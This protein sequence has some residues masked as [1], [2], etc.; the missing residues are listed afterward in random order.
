M[1]HVS[2]KLDLFESASENLK[3]L[4]N[5]PG[6][7]VKL[8]LYAFFK[9]ATIGKC[10]IKKPFITDLVGR[11]KWD[12]WNELKNMEKIE[13][14]EKYI[15]LVN[16]LLKAENIHLNE[17]EQTE[18]EPMQEIFTK[19]NNK[20]KEIITSIEFGNVFKIT[21]NRPNKFNAFSKE[22]YL[23]V[24]AAIKEANENENILMLC[25]T[26][27]GEYFSSGNDL[28]NF[29]QITG[30]DSYEKLLRSGCQLVE[31]LCDTLI[32]FSKPLI[33][34]VNGPA[35]GI[36]F[37]ILGL[38]DYVIASEKA[39]FH[40]PFT[41]L[42]LSPEGCSSY[43]FPKIMGNLK[44]AEVLLFNKKL[45]AQEA[46]ECGFVSEIIPKENFEIRAS[47]KLKILSKIPK[48]S[49]L[50]STKLFRDFNRDKDKL[51]EVNKTEMETLYQRF[52]SGD[53]LQSVMAFMNK[54]SKL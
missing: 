29:T 14:K 27:N 35:V 3:L 21:L 6:N 11:A 26:G 41:Q 38:F 52:L 44:A 42:A 7:D 48:D 25:L 28:T 23:E 49:L 13:A 43:T 40:C 9:Q 47:E 45:S 54:K 19:E 32:D 5:E 46:Y 33:A 15:D 1:S 36:S 20:Y 12:S 10:N 51:K 22:M 17:K 8:K 37:T 18:L 24:N 53:F 50:Q 39:T 2:K 16:K 30:S 34:F 4:K 31:D